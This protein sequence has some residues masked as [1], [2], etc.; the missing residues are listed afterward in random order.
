L[1]IAVAEWLDSLGIKSA[2]SF[3]KSTAEKSKQAASEKRQQ[4]LEQ[5]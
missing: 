5:Q 4:K 1:P 2:S 3:L